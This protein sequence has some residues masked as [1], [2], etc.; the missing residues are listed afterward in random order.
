MIIKSFIQIIPTVLA[1]AGLLMQPKKDIDKPISISNINKAG[2]LMCVVILILGAASTFQMI[3]SEK[4]SKVDKDELKQHNSTLQSQLSMLLDSNRILTKVVSVGDGYNA[5]I[6]GTIKFRK[7]KSESEIKSALKNLFSKFVNINLVAY[8]E[9]G[10]HQGRID[11]SVNPHIRRFRRVSEITSNSDL[12]RH[13]DTSM[14]GP[15]SY[16]FEVK[17]ENLKILN[18]D[19]IQFVM[20][21]G[22]TLETTVEEFSHWRDFGSLYNVDH[23]YISDLVV[24]ELSDYSINKHLDF[25]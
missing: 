10:K 3:D 22:S 15:Y 13:V 17:V 21:N 1:L 23:I 18:K 20:I 25:N 11:H 16:F 8:N 24:E 19:K 12:I 2:I 7:R 5:H 9:L 4:K 6:R 14:L